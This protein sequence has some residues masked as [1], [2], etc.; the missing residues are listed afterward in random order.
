ML[1]PA[2]LALGML[3][4][5]CAAKESPPD[6]GP[7]PPATLEEAIDK[8]ISAYCEH[9]ARCEVSTDQATCE[10]LFRRTLVHTPNDADSVQGRLLKSIAKGRAT[11][12]GAAAKACIELFKTLPCDVDAIATGACA[13]FAA[14]KVPAGMPCYSSADCTTDAFCTADTMVSGP[15]NCPGTC[16]LRAAENATT[17]AYSGCQASLYAYTTSSTQLTCKKK[18]EAGSSCAPAAP[19]TTT[20]QCVV[21]ATCNGATCVAKKGAGVM[22][23]KDDECAFNLRC[24]A[25]VCGARLAVGGICT[26]S[27]SGSATSCRVGATCIRSG[28]GANSGTCGLPGKD[29]AACNGG[30]ECD[31]GFYCVGAT[32]TTA[33]VCRAYRAENESCDVLG[34]A[35]RCGEGLYCALGATCAKK[36]PASASCA[37]NSECLSN[38]CQSASCTA[39]TDV[40]L[41]RT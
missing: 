17:T 38:S 20:Q 26:L 30:D 6:A 24:Q 11:Y 9:S 23:A 25:G 8:S 12:D 1:R 2:L 10:A 29:G 37:V 19:G 40:C 36:K 15:S 39:P 7:P 27:P 31:F 28:P 33:G 18:V 35:P 34:G 13:P 22:C 5:S 16:A 4:V 14:G 32:G 3:V 21:T 41:D